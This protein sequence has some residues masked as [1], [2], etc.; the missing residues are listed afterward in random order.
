M[1]RYKMARWKQI[2]RSGPVHRRLIRSTRDLRHSH[3]R[4]P[5]I[6]AAVMLTFAW[7]LLPLL[8]GCGRRTPT[9]HPAPAPDTTASTP[10]DVS[11]PNSQPTNPPAPAAGSTITFRG[12]DNDYRG[13]TRVMP[14]KQ[15]VHQKESHD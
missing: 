7:L 6:V 3:F 11:T 15:L 8:P 2:L 4:A 12:L 9:S 1:Q 14:D 5:R 10:E 13:T